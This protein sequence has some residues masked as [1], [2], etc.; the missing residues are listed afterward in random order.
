MDSWTWT[1]ENVQLLRTEWAAG[2][3]SGVIAA[4]LGITR[5]AVI[6]KISRLHLARRTTLDTRT[7]GRPRKSR[8][9]VPV[10]RRKPAKARPNPFGGRSYTIKY[11][12]AP[13]AP[14]DGPGATLQNRTGCC[15]PINDGNPYLFCDATT[16]NGSYC[17]YHRQAMYRAPDVAPA[18]MG[19][20]T[21]GES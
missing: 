2:K 18:K 1:A 12:K 14:P 11:P 17:E 10:L 3:S 19:N 8:A 21:A 4:S 20:L 15:F 5:N 7:C 13:V 6:G 16:E 9:G